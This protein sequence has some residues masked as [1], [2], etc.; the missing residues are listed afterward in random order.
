[1]AGGQAYFTLNAENQLL[2][3]A[4]LANRI[5]QVTLNLGDGAVFNG[6]ANPDNQ[7]DSMVVKL[8]SGA[9]WE[10]TEDSYVTTLVDEDENF[11]NIKSNGHNIYYSKAE[12]ALA[13]RP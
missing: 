13:A 9:T 10:L 1:M 5:S 3:G 12:I 4:V 2:E 6:S 8:K 7:A 11:N